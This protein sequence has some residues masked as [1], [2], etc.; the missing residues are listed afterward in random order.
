MS[1]LLSL[2]AAGIVAGCGVAS[3]GGVGTASRPVP[4]NG[5]P[6]PGMLSFFGVVELTAA[7]VGGLSGLWVSEDGKRLAAVS[8][9]GE[10][11]EA[12]LSYDPRG[13]L[14]SVSDLTVTPLTLETGAGRGK[15]MGDSEELAR[16]PERAGGGW[17]V[18][19]ER[20]HRIL[21]YPAS[22]NGPEGKPERLPIPEALKD[23]PRNGG[24]E[25]MAALSDGRLLILEEGD[26]DG[27][28]ER[29]GWIA[30]ALPGG[31]EQADRKDS[32]RKGGARGKDARIG[33]NRLTYRAAPGF[34]PAGA[35]LLPDGGALVLERR[36]SF[37]GGWGTR[38]VRLPA[39]ALKAGAVVEGE[40][41]A[42][43]E[44]P[45]PTD[46]YEGIA[47]RPVAGGETL[48][49]LL[50]DDNF[51]PIQRSYLMMLALPANGK[52]EARES[53]LSGRRS[54]L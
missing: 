28:R 21:R 18:S 6:S 51:S 10:R 47:V 8:D 3:G 30:D 2:L 34:R 53:A 42:S 43:I 37:L 7:G 13:R 41:L 20:E 4:L 35:A 25:A 16:L 38:I 26:D 44:P 48:I 50:S 36:A 24:I 52:E 54:A 23:A 12:R 17:L 46:N 33:W 9:I 29:R 1:T 40:E 11:V 49:Y 15:R 22:P 32:G 45:L 27:A 19:F 39:S 31:V 14:S 5:Q